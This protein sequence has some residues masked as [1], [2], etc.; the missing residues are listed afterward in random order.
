MGSAA[1]PRRNRSTLFRAPGQC[2]GTSVEGMWCALRGY[3]VVFG[4]VP[5]ANGPRT[6]S[7]TRMAAA[8]TVPQS[9]APAMEG[10]EFGKASQ[11]YEKSSV[12][13]LHVAIAPMRAVSAAIRGIEWL[14][15]RALSTGISSFARRVE[16]FSGVVRS[17]SAPRWHGTEGHGSRPARWGRGIRSGDPKS[18][19]GRAE[20]A[21]RIFRERSRNR[22]RWT[23]GRGA[24]TPMALL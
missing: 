17:V 12:A 20:V 11:A 16:I 10:C 9:T 1:D 3:G 15:L 4:S 5:N 24:K 14:K 22:S 8:Q 13:Q 21:A 19:S 23:E 6:L 18:R 2:V 7:M